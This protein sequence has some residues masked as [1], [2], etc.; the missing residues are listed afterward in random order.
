MI[1]KGGRADT[2]T[3]PAPIDMVE[4]FVNFRPREHWPKRALK[5]ADASRQ[6]RA[7]LSTLEERGY[8]HIDNADDREKL[9]NV[10]DQWRRQR[11]DD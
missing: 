1:G 3:D 2:P 9:Q 11:H 7:T 10:V 6:V 5:F 4:T 8:V